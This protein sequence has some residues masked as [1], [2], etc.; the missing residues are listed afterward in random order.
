MKY[1]ALIL[2]LLKFAVVLQTAT[3]AW[4]ILE[5]GSKVNSYFFHVHNVSD[6]VLSQFDLVLGYLMYALALW[7]MLKPSK[8]PLITLSA[9]FFML[10][11]FKTLYGGAAFTD[12]AVFAA[13]IRIVLPVVYLAR[14]SEEGIIRERILLL[15]RLAIVAT[16]VMHGYECIMGHGTFVDYVIGSA[17]N[18]INLEVSESQA[19]E[20]LRW[21]GI[22]DIAVALLLLGV[23]WTWVPA[24]M[25]FWGTVAAFSRIT[26]SGWDG[27]WFK[28]CVRVAN[29]VGP[30][31]LF[32][33]FLSRQSKK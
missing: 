13:A 29:G 30:F 19:L 3:A 6:D 20:V 22:V 5:F 18:L 12:G 4:M 21:I 2:K 9:L 15:L 11:V 17:H 7:V 27:A 24:Y 14:L 16:F 33:A 26:H 32:L 25:A 23:N 1:D 31:V 28:T 10:S 8:I